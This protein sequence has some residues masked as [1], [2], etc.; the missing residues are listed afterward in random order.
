[1]RTHLQVDDGSKLAEMFIEFADV[2]K[3]CRN[4]PHQQLGVGGEWRS[5][6]VAL[7]VWLVEVRSKCRR[8]NMKQLGEWG[9][10]YNSDTDT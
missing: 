8:Q 3:L 1:M 10:E 9:N 2:V 5:F 7:M 4:L 6:M